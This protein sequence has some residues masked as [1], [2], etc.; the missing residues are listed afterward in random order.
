MASGVVVAVLTKLVSL[1]VQVSAISR[2]RPLNTKGDITFALGL[3][4]RV[5][6]RAKGLCERPATLAGPISAVA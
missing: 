1:A 2:I 6:V 5:V 3:R 4:G